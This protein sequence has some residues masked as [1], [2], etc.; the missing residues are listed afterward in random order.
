MPKKKKS[1]RKSPRKEYISDRMP[2]SS[3]LYLKK[4][5]LREIIKIFYLNLPQ[6][7]LS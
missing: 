4:T 5:D 3:R 2:T 6:Q 7:F 1:P